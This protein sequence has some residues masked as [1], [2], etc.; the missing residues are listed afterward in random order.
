M[1]KYRILIART[2]WLYYWLFKIRKMIKFIE[3]YPNDSSKKIGIIKL[4]KRGW[5]YAKKNSSSE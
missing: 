5:S 4:K 3:V 2:H 1:K